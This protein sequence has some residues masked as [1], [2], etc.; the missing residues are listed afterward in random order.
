MST[1][2][3]LGITLKLSGR[4][5]ENDEYAALRTDSQI[6][7]YYQENGY[8]VIRGLLPEELCDR[9]R[10]HFL[11]EVKSYTGYIYRQA[12]AR[13]EKHIFTPGGHMLNAIM[14]VQDLNQRTFPLFRQVS[15]EVLTHSQLLKGATAILQHEAIM[16]QSMYF[17]GN[18]AT[19]A[20]LDSDYLDSSQAG[21]MV[22]AWIALEDIH[23]QAGR[24][25]IYP[26]SHQI[27]VPNAQHIVLD[28]AKYEEVILQTIADQ[29]L[30]CK[31]PALRK[32]DVLFWHGDTIHGSLPTTDSAFSRSSYTAHFIARHSH[33]L[34]YHLIRKHLKLRK[35]QDAYVNF[36]K[37][38]NELRNQL[39]F[40]LETSFPSVFRKLKRMAIRMNMQLPHLL[41]KFSKSNV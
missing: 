40:N 34:Q 26:K 20:H 38:Q 9:A 7:Q 19:W 16:A 15:L 11:N 1:L 10:K 8:V 24:F 37:D 12:S 3:P 17:E 29:G 27:K 18:P 14:N 2:L 31:V 4:S 41:G 6:R 30:T 25:Y 5:Q 28:R 13:P 32:G 35:Y 39:I 21:G 33:L 22:G 36:P 23:P